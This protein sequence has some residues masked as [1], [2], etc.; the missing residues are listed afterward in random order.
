M[1][2]ALLT[3]ED[4][5]LLLHKSVHSIRCDVARNPSALPPRCKIPGAKRLLWMEDV[6]NAWLSECVE[7]TQDALPHAKQN[8]PLVKPQNKKRVGRPTNAERLARQQI[9]Q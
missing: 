6:V 2:L 8:K 9:G 4:L 1:K 7:K 5:A 3:V